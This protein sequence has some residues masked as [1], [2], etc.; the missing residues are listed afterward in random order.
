MNTYYLKRILKIKGRKKGYL[1]Q[2]KEKRGKTGRQILPIN[3]CY[4]RKSNRKLF[5]GEGGGV[6]TVRDSSISTVYYN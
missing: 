4:Y 1:C 3:L 2:G 6:G 5:L